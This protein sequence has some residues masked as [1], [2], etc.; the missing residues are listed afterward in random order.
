ME[1]KWIYDLYIS[2][3]RAFKD[4]LNTCFSFEIGHSK[5]KLW[6]LKVASKMVH[7]KEKTQGYSLWFSQILTSHKTHI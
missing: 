2:S 4:L 5:I 3:E 6:P 1:E 7:F